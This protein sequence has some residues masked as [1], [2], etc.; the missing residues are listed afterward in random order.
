MSLFASPK[1]IAKN[2]IISLDFDGVLAH[3]LDA[4]IHYAKKW[5]D[6]NLSLS[7]TKKDGFE[8]LAHH[9]GKKDINYRSLM[10]PLN[11]KHIMEYKVPD[12]C[13]SVLKKLHSEGFRFV[14]ITSRNNHD[15][16]YA[17][18]FVKHKFGS[19]IKF[20]HNTRNEPKT[21]FVRRLRPRVHLDDDLKKLVELQSEPVSLFYYR[22]PENAHV[23]LPLGTSRIKEV[24]SWEQFYHFC[25]DLKMLHEA[26]CWKFDVVNDYRHN[27]EIVRLCNHLSPDKKHQLLSEYASSKHKKVA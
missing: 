17:V 2:I 25:H 16:P 15:Y 21:E 8:E 7:Q 1:F 27:T 20:I 9:L 12:G 26:V 24:H 4:K 11:E 22:Q 14:I 6:M 3:G 18:H 5:F 23:H 13:I 19:L 10:D